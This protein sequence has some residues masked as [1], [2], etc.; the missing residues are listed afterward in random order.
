[1]CACRRSDPVHSHSQH[2]HSDTQPVAA[3][4][5]GR[6]LPGAS[7]LVFRCTARRG[8]PALNCSAVAKSSAALGFACNAGTDC[9]SPLTTFH[10]DHPDDA[11]NVPA[12]IAKLLIIPFVCLVERFW[13]GKQFSVR[14]IMSVVTVVFGVA[15]V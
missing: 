14:V 12:Q 5:Q 11:S 1:M 8:Q 10:P 2:I 13:L 3:A 6:L 7:G 9:L 4:Q 15:V